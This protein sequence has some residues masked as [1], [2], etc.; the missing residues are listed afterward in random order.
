MQRKHK[1]RNIF[2]T[3]RRVD[4]FF[5]VCTVQL[6]QSEIGFLTYLFPWLISSSQIQRG[7]ETKTQSTNLRREL[8]LANRKTLVRRGDTK[9]R[10]RD[11]GGK[12]IG[13]DSQLEGYSLV[14]G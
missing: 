6:H 2:E 14:H 8:R 11:T 12:Q 3:L 13:T 5:S 7:G 1:I 10:S 4:D 9:N